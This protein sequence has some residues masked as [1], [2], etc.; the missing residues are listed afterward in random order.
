M[1]EVA[2]SGVAVSEV[3]KPATTG[4]KISPKRIIK[5]LK[6]KPAPKTGGK[7]RIMAV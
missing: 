1:A 7:W 3:L 5:P 2:V 4:T 6:I